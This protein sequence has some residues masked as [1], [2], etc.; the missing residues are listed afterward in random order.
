MG[1]QWKGASLAQDGAT[2]REEKGGPIRITDDVWP[3]MVQSWQG[4]DVVAR[5]T[6]DA[7]RGIV[8]P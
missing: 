5:G 4:G 8:T 3:T 7:R 6:G 2:W 1:G